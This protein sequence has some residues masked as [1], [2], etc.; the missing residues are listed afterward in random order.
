MKISIHMILEELKDLNPTVHLNNISHFSSYSILEQLPNDGEILYICDVTKFVSMNNISDK[1]TFICVDSLNI[2][3]EVEISNKINLIAINKNISMSNLINRIISIFNKYLNF[4]LNIKSSLNQGVNLE[5]ILNYIYQTLSLEM[6]LNDSKGNVLFRNSN[7]YKY[8]PQSVVTSRTVRDGNKQL[9]ALSLM[10]SKT[11]SEDYQISLFN[12]VYDILSSKLELYFNDKRDAFQ[13][14]NKMILDSIANNQNIDSEALVRRVSTVGWGFEDHYKL[15]YIM[16][17]KYESIQLVIDYLTETYKKDTILLKHEGKYLLLIN[18]EKIDGDILISELKL[19]L[20]NKSD[21][22][23]LVS[24][25]YK[26]LSDTRNHYNFLSKL[27]VKID[28]GFI[29]LSVDIIKTLLLLGQDFNSNVFINSEIQKLKEFDENNDGDLLETLYAYI[30]YERS[31]VKTA[32]MLNVHRNTIV[33][34][35]N[36]IE[37]IIKLDL[38]NAQVRYHIIISILL[39]MGDSLLKYK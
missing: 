27:V 14:L 28:Y 36:K 12:Q 10:K 8:Y 29:D 37:E 16:S 2:L 15:F 32:E 23:I 9:G 13:D 18:T 6:Y 22:K 4:E 31:L 34:R 35:V 7:A 3:E 24:I 19:M 39:I 26:D 30:C 11:L 25:P 1:K 5:T 21:I 17:Q 20:E 38:N 33:Y